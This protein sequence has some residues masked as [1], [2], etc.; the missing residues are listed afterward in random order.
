[1]AILLKNTAMLLKTFWLPSVASSAITGMSQSASQTAD[2]NKA[3]ATLGRA[4][5]GSSSPNRLLS[6]PYLSAPLPCPPSLL[7][8]SAPLAV[9]KNPIAAA[10]SMMTGNGILKKNADEC[11]R[12]QQSEDV[13][14][15]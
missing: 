11:R 7:K 2:T 4:C 9:P 12:G 15:Q 8:T 3:R 14:F 1:M 5:S 10:P 6:S 13:V